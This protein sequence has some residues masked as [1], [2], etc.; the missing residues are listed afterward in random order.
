MERGVSVD[1][2]EAARS[3]SSW[4][5]RKIC[6]G[7]LGRGL[8]AGQGPG[9]DTMSLHWWVPVRAGERTLGEGSLMSFAAATPSA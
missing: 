1:L 9:R 3:R 4:H 8:W 7:C 6:P 5:L 2:E